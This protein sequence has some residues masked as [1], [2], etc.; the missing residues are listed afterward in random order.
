[1]ATTL[2]FREPEVADDGRS[3]IYDGEWD[4]W[5]ILV[6]TDGTCSIRDYAEEEWLEGDF[7]TLDAAKA[8][9][10]RLYEAELRAVGL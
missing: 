2:T 4:R 9:V 10:Q 1:M 5:M 7:P 3:R 8:E 6:Q